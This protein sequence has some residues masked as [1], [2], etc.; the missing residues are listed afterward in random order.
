MGRGSFVNSTS[1]K[2]IFPHREAAGG[3]ERWRDRK[4][5]RSGVAVGTSLRSQWR[6]CRLRP[7]PDWKGLQRTSGN[8]RS[9]FQKT[10]GK[11]LSQT[12]IVGQSI[13]SGVRRVAVGEHAGGR[14]P[15]FERTRPWDV[16]FREATND[17]AFWSDNEDRPPLQFARKMASSAKLADEGFWPPG[18]HTR[19]RDGGGRRGRG[20]KHARST[21]SSPS[22]RPQRCR[23][24]AKR[25]GKS[26]TVEA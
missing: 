20:K 9:H 21:S 2:P 26:K 10:D 5:S 15:E 3:A 6:C 14:L 12:L 11:W 1:S 24:N 17:H 25:V 23:L 7:Q 22:V 19:G 8:W 16:V 18:S 4:L 13:W